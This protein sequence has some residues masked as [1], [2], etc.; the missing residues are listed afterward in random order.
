MNRRLIKQNK[1][2]LSIVTILFI[3][4]GSVL[5]FGVNQIY[6]REAKW[7]HGN[8]VSQL[9]SVKENIKVLFADLGHDLFFLRNISSTREYINSNYES[10]NYRS[11]VEKLLYEFAKVCKHYYQ[12]SIIDSSGSEVIGIDNRLDNAPVITPKTQLQNSKHRDYFQNA[13]KL[14]NNQIY[15]S[16]IHSGIQ[17]EEIAEQNFPMIELA[18]SLFSSKGERKGILALNMYSTR[19]LKLLPENIF[20]QTGDGNL[21]SLRPDG[22]ISFNESQ[23]DFSDSFGWIDISDDETIHYSDVE[24]LPGKKLVVAIFHKHPMLKA[25]LQR[26]IV[27]SI[28][29]LSIFLCLILIIGYLN[30]LRFRE[31]IGAQRAIIFSLAKLA[32]HRDSG[33]GNHLERT[34]DYSIILAKQLRKNKK[35]KRIITNEFIEDLYDAAPLHDIGKVGIRDSILLKESKLT[36][37]EYGKMKGHVRIGEHILQDAI[38]IFKLKQPFLVMGKNICAYHHEKY[39]GKGYP[40]GLKGEEIPVEVKLFTLCDAY[41]T[42]R[43]KRSYKKELSHEEAVRRIRSDKGE[44]FDPDI[45]AAFLKCENEFAIE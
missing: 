6:K 43:S 12:I 38:D 27:V 33:T 45:V 3:L 17:K 40:D 8:A 2:F 20:I 21:I 9:L 14:D 29:L 36:E 16:P 30:F 28:I 35:Y 42:I 15:V 1:I 26:L 37:E 7:R 5:Y 41:D 39:N 31:L 23:Y 4:I 10:I 25:L 13:M 32:E 11:E 34:R 44:H 24:I 19:L 22:S 18:M